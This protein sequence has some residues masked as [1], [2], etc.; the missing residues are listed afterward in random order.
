MTLLRLIL[1]YCERT[2]VAETRFGRAAIGDPN[3]VRNLRR[4]KAISAKRETWVRQAIA[5]HPDGLPGAA[6]RPARTHDFRRPAPDEP[7]DG[8]PVGR[9]RDLA[10]E[11]GSRDLLLAMLRYG[12][13]VGGLPGLDRVSFRA[14]CGEHGLNLRGKI[15][16]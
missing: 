8:D 16:R 15:L 1:D 13:S 12:L 6:G 3:L 10:A 4:G 9:V 14:L 11:Q 7:G 2:G 5:N